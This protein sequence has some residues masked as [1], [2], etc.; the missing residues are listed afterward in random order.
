MKLSSNVLFLGLASA[1][2]IVSSCG[3]ETPNKNEQQELLSHQVDSTSAI[4]AE[5]EGKIFSIPSPIQTAI[6]LKQASGSYNPNLVNPSE[7]AGKYATTYSRA[8]NL[9]VY[10]ADM[11]YAT[12]FGQQKESLSYLK[13]LQTL[14][15]GLSISGAFDKTFAERFILTFSFSAKF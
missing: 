13:A 7:N 15:D 10:G 11:G 12:L 5:F 8:L 2:L 3:G 1:A 9:G 6:L 14:S 4:N